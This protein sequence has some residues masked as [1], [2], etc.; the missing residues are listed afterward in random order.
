MPLVV[1]PEGGRAPDGSVQE[2]LA[3]A[4]YM[5][6]RA[7]VPLVPLTVVGTYEVLPMHVYHLAPRP[8]LLVVGE[9]IPTGGLT[10]RDA[11]RLTEQ[12]RREITRTY[13]RYSA[14]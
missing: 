3:G 6:I 4:A 2:F 14:S 11:E 10:T 9:A 7:Q 12:V 1:F 13:L 5:A 8:L